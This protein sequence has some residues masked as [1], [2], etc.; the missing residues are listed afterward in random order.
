MN[1][2]KTLFHKLHQDDRGDIPVGNLLIIGLIAIPLV[3]AL[4]AFRDDIDKWIKGEWKKVETES[5]KKTGP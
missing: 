1:R 5:A 3:I 2:I 4:I